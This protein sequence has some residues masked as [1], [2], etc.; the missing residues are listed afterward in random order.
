MILKMFSQVNEGD[1]VRFHGHLI[2]PG[3]AHKWRKVIRVDREVMVL[4]DRNGREMTVTYDRC[5]ASGIRFKT[6]E[7]GDPREDGDNV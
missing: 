6:W 4:V 5:Q 7:P 1:Y 2:S 3:H